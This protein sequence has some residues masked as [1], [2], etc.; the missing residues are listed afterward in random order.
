MTEPTSAKPSFFRRVPIAIVYPL[1]LILSASLALTIY[2]TISF[3][4]MQTMLEQDLKTRMSGV[5]N[6]IAEGFVGLL[7]DTEQ[8]LHFL[9]EVPRTVQAYRA[10]SAAYSVIPGSTDE[11]RVSLQNSFIA[12][13]PYPPSQRILMAD[14]QDETAYG[15]AHAVYHAWFASILTRYDLYDV[16]LVTPE[17]L[18]I[19]TA[20]KEADLGADLT[21]RAFADTGL[22]LAYNK[23]ARAVEAGQFEATV[24]SGFAPYRISNGTVAGFM[25]HPILDAQGRFHGQ[26]IV[27][28]KPDAFEKVLEQ[29]GGK[30]GQTATDVVNP[31]LVPVFSRRPDGADVTRLGPQ[32]QALARDAL[33]GQTDMTIEHLDGTEQAFVFKRPLTF[34]DQT[35][36]LVWRVPYNVAFSVLSSLRWMTF[37]VSCGTLMLIGVLGYLF[38]RQR[39]RPIREVEVRLARLAETRDLSA[40]FID[41]SAD[42]TASSAR[43]LDRLLG[44][45]ND[46]MHEMRRAAR[47]SESAAGEVS[48]KAKT[49]TEGAQ[50]Q[51]TATQQLSASITETE[52]QVTESA[53]A[54]QQAM[55]VIESALAVVETGRANTDRLVET[56]DAI[57]AESARIESV[58]QLI[59]NIAFQ[60]NLL[61]LNAA[62]E[63]A[64]AGPQGRG[65][66]VV[67]Q[68][69]RNLAQRSATAA[70]ETS[71][72]LENAQKAVTSGVSV[73]SDT[74]ESFGHIEQQMQDISAFVREISVAGEQQSAA[75]RQISAAISE[76]SAI[77]LEN[78]QTAEEMED[79]AARQREAV[80]STQQVLDQFTLRDDP[81]NGHE[82]APARTDQPNPVVVPLRERPQ[83]RKAEK[84]E[85]APSLDYDARSYGGF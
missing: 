49:L 67:A 63:A 57:K 28:L 73:S 30:I 68:E 64:R 74:A 71:N 22:G 43:A 52:N 20:F 12:R 27:Q 37:F 59:D 81:A 18:V 13:N 42:E 69:V 61:A 36:A 85:S 76:I 16:F 47:R 23:L 62:V 25:A 79:T 77:T 40:R 35:L 15:A 39:V 11:R 45:L 10:I 65:F 29:A 7:S 44:T 26:L 33:A 55:D 34:K 19:Y 72:L 1:T 5:G 56:M 75:V 38:G 2:A 21:S 31:D 80:A 78:A 4:Q 17:G 58:V 41:N 54:A 70:K 32:L 53:R 46:S 51:A 6:T 84:Q 60:T 66:A 3:L 83:P 24:F 9:A 82:A 48:A 8:D 14:P 50:S